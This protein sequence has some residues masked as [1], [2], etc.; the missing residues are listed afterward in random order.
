MSAFAGSAAFYDALYAGK[1]YAGEA[2]YVSDL[3][4]RFVPQARNVVDFGCGTAR[5][6]REFAEMDF[7]VTGVDQSAAML[8][9][10]KEYL[11][12]AAP[13]I[14]DNIALREGDIRNVRLGRRFDAVVAL[15]HVMSYQA[16]NDDL[17]A[18]FS[19][20]AAH[21]VSGGI[22]IFDFWYGPGVLQDPPATRVKRF[23]SGSRRIVRIAEPVLHSNANLVD[24]NY[25]FIMFG[26]GGCEEFSETHRMRYLFIPE[27]EM[28]LRE[29][30]LAPLFCYEWMKCESPGDQ[31][32]NAV[33]AARRS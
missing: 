10:A 11:S 14:R 2:K 6:A 23:T 15:F 20:A 8:G 26:E 33:F 12:G 22:F 17:S 16:T 1:D 28:L 19:T 32:W 3:I 24:V 13:E 9:R 21:L 5:H 27:V 18:A 4:R 29:N 31:S 7:C 30:N 25:Q